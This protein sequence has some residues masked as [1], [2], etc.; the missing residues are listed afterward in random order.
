MSLKKYPRKE[1]IVIIK[2][3]AVLS[4]DINNFAGHIGQG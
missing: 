1:L 4:L 2:G 3:Y